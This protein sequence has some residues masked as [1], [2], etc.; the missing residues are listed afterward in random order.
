MCVVWCHVVLLCSV[1]VSFMI[2]RDLVMW[3]S[4]VGLWR[5]GVVGLVMVRGVEVWLSDV[6]CWFCGGWGRGFGFWL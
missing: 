6:V 1:R 5:C 3:C 4:D 2:V